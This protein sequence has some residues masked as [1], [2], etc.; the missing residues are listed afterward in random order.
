M[1]RFYRQGSHKAFGTHQDSSQS[2]FHLNE[3]QSHPKQLALISP[4]DDIIDLEFGLG[5]MPKNHHHDAMHS[6]PN[7]ELFDEVMFDDDGT[8]IAAPPRFT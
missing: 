6:D 7:E 8:S 5:Q 2:N 4:T 3:K 1:G